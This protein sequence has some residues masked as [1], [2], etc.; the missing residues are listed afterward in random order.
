VN[1]TS[2]P[3]TAPFAVWA[4]AIIL[5]LVVAGIP[6]FLLIARNQAPNMLEWFALVCT[7]LIVAM[8]LWPAQFHYHF[9]AF[10]APFLGLAIALPLAGLLNTGDRPAPGD[11]KTG[12]PSPRPGAGNVPDGLSGGLPSRRRPRP[13]AVAA[14]LVAVMAVVQA[15]NEGGLT[16]VVPPQIIAQTDRLI[17]QG[18]CVVSDNAALLL[19]A[20]RFTANMPGCT[21]I[22]DGRGT[23]LALSRGLT[24][25]TG[26]G[27]IPAVA[28]LW[29]QSFSRAQFLWLT[30]RFSRRVAGSPALWRYV[31]RHFTLIFTDSSGDWLYRRMRGH[32]GRFRAKDHG[33][34]VSGCGRIPASVVEHLHEVEVTPGTC[35]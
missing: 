22:D 28:T 14:V 16:A 3:H 10:L 1:L 27:L 29:R 12:P 5:L 17:P 34:V 33:V 7:E 13:W 18:S 25:E 8:F 20:N 6:A 4:L 30:R 32:H 9:A 26:A 19:L 21:V 11:G 24:P 23:D 35:G 2:G 31:H 15:I